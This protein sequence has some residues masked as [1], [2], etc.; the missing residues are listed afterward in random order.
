MIKNST[1]LLNAATIKKARLEAA[2]S[3]AN[4]LLTLEELIA[5]PRE[6][7]VAQLAETFGYLPLAMD[8]LHQL[9]PAFD[10]IPFAEA[11]QHDCLLFRDDSGKFS[12]ISRC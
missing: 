7:F 11:S 6:V 3:G 4:L 5:E 9:A 2:N 12:T 8:D 1:K 10:V